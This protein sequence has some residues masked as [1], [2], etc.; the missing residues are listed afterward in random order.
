MSERLRKMLAV[1]LLGCVC[2]SP[3]SAEPSV[4]V[5]QFVEHPSLDACRQGIR[6][7]LALAGFRAGDNLGWTY[8]SA[9]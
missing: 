5:T 3:V 7:A 4:A 9:Q 2:S 6:D 8:E 1:A